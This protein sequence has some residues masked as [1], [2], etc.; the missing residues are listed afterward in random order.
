MT[1]EKL[2]KSFDKF[3][4]DEWRGQL[5]SLDVPALKSVLTDIAKSEERNQKAKEEDEDLARCVEAKSVAELSYKEE[6]TVNKFK[7]KFALRVLATKET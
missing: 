5:E 4:D 3:L 1:E 7:M 6:S 2:Q